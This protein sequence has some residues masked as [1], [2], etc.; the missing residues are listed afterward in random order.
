[1]D[2]GVKTDP[3]YQ[4]ER[5]QKIIS[6]AKEIGQESQENNLVSVTLL[7]QKFVQQVETAVKELKTI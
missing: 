1:M 5:T 4:D 2:T 3:L 7:V 6:R